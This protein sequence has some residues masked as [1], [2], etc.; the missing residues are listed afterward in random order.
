MKSDL[1]DKARLQHILLAIQ[2][3]EKYNQ[4]FS[5]SDFLDDSKTHFATIKQLE[6]IGEA[7][8]H[9]DPV[10]LKENE[11]VQWKAIR[12]FR[13]IM[14]HEY[15]AIKLERVWETIHEDLPPLK[16]SVQ[17]MLQKFF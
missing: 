10:L 1:G 15:F 2:E 13:N 7:V 17:N 9:L 6:I 5:I 11:H 12:R 3:I 16:K 8:N 14:V 4:G